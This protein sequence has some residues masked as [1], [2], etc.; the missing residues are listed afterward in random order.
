MKNSKH[1]NSLWP[2]KNKIKGI[3]DKG[4]TKEKSKLEKKSKRKNRDGEK[5]FEAVEEEQTVQKDMRLK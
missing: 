3:I 4:N 5:R 2:N 1:F